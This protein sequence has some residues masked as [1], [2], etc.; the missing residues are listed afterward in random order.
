[1]ALSYFDDALL[2]KVFSYEDIRRHVDYLGMYGKFEAMLNSSPTTGV[3]TLPGELKKT[4]EEEVIIKQIQGRI[5][6]EMAFLSRGKIVSLP[7]GLIYIVPAGKKSEYSSRFL[8]GVVVERTSKEVLFKGELYYS[9]FYRLSD[10][11]V[12]VGDDKKIFFVEDGLSVLKRGLASFMTRKFLQNDSVAEKIIDADSEKTFL[13]YREEY[14]RSK[15]LP[16]EEAQKC[17]DSAVINGTAFLLM[18]LN[19]GIDPAE[20]ITLLDWLKMRNKFF[21]PESK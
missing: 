14:V 2:C 1:M 7:L 21:I 12:A 15:N 10:S 9:L 8:K 20:L 13:S 18:M 5:N 17:F 19:R 16:A 3:L 4:D 11:V 6:E